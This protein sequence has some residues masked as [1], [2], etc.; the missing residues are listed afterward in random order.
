M[1]NT[2][3]KFELDTEIRGLLHKASFSLLV[4]MIF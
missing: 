2:A 1:K 4:F 3:G